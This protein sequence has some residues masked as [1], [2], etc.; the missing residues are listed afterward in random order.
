MLWEFA[1]SPLQSSYYMSGFFF[2]TTILR[3][4]WLRVIVLGKMSSGLNCLPD[5]CA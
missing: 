3:A 4:E 1:R 5:T 2:S